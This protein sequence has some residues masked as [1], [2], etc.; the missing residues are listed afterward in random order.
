MRATQ[1]RERQVRREVA[2]DDQKHAAIGALEEG[3]P[4][5]LG[6]WVIGGEDEQRLLV[7]RITSAMVSAA[8]HGGG[9]YLRGRWPDVA[10]VSLHERDELIYLNGA[11]ITKRE[12]CG[13]RWFDEAL[14]RPLDFTVEPWGQRCDYQAAEREARR[15]LESRVKALREAREPVTG[16]NI[17]RCTSCGQ[18]SDRLMG[19]AD[20]GVLCPACRPDLPWD[21]VRQEGDDTD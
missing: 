14:H 10:W 12:A 2:L 9:W 7:E 16:W 19:L 11:S 1:K 15:L 5:M 20:T 21:P 8:V 3:S 4:Q 6:P 17:P 18:A 13:D